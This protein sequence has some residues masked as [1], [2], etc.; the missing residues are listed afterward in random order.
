[1]LPEV[2]AL[3]QHVSKTVFSLPELSNN[4]P[5]DVEISVVLTDDKAIQLL[6]AD[7]RGKNKPT[8]VLS[9]PSFD[10]EPGKPFPVQTIP[11]ECIL[12]DII[13]AVETIEREA[14]EQ[15]KPIAAH[16]SH[17]LVHGVL[18]LLGYDHEVESEAEIME[19]L[20]VKLLAQLGINNPY[21]TGYSIEQ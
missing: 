20:E 6:N 14:V 4:F 10:L 12:G 18:H 11:C 7:Y 21:E 15:D 2:E 17:M 13:I 5:D 16:V 1:M 3:V 19:A 9:F 8:N